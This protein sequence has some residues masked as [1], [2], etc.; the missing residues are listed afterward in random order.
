M[1]DN[2]G[3]AMPEFIFMLTRDDQTIA[4]AREVYESIAELGI[5]HV[6]CKDLGLS[7]AELANLMQD[8]RANGHTSYL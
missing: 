3:A 1:S 2:L 5:R 8:I 6:G 7:R 4:D